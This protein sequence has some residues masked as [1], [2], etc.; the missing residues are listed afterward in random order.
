IHN[1][2]AVDQ[3]VYGL[4]I[5]YQVKN[6]EVGANIHQ[7]HFAKELVPNQRLYNKFSFKGDKL[8][9]TSIYYQYTIN[10]LYLFGEAAHSFQ[11]GFATVNGLINSISHDVSIIMLHRYYEKDYY[12]FYN[13]G[14][15]EGSEAN[16]ERGLYVGLM[17]N[18]S[19]KMNWVGYA[20]Y[21]K[22]PW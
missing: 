15:A 1:K 18:P 19:R 13:Q 10:G 17:W 7:T 16:N 12:A 5:Q 21:F 3:W 2:A 6:L 9:N 8:F 20:D 14:F 11:G 22:F 4:N